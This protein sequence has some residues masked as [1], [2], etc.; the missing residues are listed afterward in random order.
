MRESTLR[1][2]KLD[3]LTGLIGGS[4]S[5]EL[6]YRGLVCRP[7]ALPQ[8]SAFFGMGYSSLSEVES[9]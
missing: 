1:P 3:I 9:V 4:F 7:L 2:P 6:A 8:R 5:K